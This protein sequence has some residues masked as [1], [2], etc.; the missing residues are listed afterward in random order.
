[1]CWAA[2]NPTVMQLLVRVGMEPA[3]KERQPGGGAGLGKDKRAGGLPAPLSI[4]VKVPGAMQHK[5][6]EKLL[7][8]WHQC[9]SC[10]LA[11]CN[12]PHKNQCIW[13]WEVG[14]VLKGCAQA[15]SAGYSKPGFLK[16]VWLV[17]NHGRG[18]KRSR[19]RHSCKSNWMEKSVQLQTVR[20]LDCLNKESAGIVCMDCVDCASQELVP[21]ASQLEPGSGGDVKDED[22]QILSAAAAE[23]GQ[24]SRHS[25]RRR[26]GPRRLRGR[27]S[28]SGRPRRHEQ[29]RRTEQSSQC[30]CWHHHQRRLIAP[31]ACSQMAHRQ[32]G[33]MR[34]RN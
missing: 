6:G 3:E 8:N 4:A 30:H 5:D 16:P 26:R 31:K 17:P 18:C 13:C 28:H 20:N 12:S 29:K 32:P 11:N 27:R 24:Q 1:M 21:P 33:H 22:K 19:P 9:G 23:Q 7:C 14:H 2:I 10:Q 15:K 25:R 34:W